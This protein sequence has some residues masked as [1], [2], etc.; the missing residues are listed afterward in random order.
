LFRN[1]GEA[2]NVVLAR[3]VIAHHGLDRPLSEISSRVTE[4]YFRP[5][6]IMQRM[7]DGWSR[8]I[9]SYGVELPFD[10]AIR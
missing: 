4:R 5:S 3:R 1:G 8:H 7:R 2:L 9:E 6:N 10:D